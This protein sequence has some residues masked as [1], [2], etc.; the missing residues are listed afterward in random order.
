MTTA[1]LYANAQQLRALADDFELQLD[2]AVVL[3]QEPDGADLNI[4]VEFADSTEPHDAIV[5]VRGE[6]HTVQ[7]LESIEEGKR[8]A[9]LMANYER[10]REA[11]IDEQL[12]HDYDPDLVELDP[13]DRDRIQ[14]ARDD[15]R[16][17]PEGEPKFAV[18][19]LV[20]FQGREATVTA[21]RVTRAN[22]HEY[23]IKPKLPGEQ[24]GP[25]TPVMERELRYAVPEQS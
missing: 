9:A 12:D 18:G 5:D 19:D 17:V 16:G 11:A 21:H 25:D 15:A 22:G 20:V 2:D 4:R 23:V 13:E 6:V 10:D 7:S 3:S 24:W 8:E 1:K 14:A